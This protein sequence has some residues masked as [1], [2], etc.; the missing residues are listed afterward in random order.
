MNDKNAII[1]SVLV[2]Q[3][4]VSTERKISCDLHTLSD[5]LSRPDSEGVLLGYLSESFPIEKVYLLKI[6][7]IRILGYEFDGCN[8]FDGFNFT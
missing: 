8:F 5:I 7:C 1:P 2:L 3:P 4:T 6:R